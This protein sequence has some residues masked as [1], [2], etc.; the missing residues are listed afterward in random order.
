MKL[1]S[2]LTDWN[3]RGYYLAMVK[4]RLFSLCPDCSVLDIS[5]SIEPF[6]IMQAAF[7]LRETYSSFPEGSV[8]IVGVL[9]EE[10]GQ[11]SH[12]VVRAHNQY[13]IGADTGLFS[14][15]FAED[16]M[17]VFELDIPADS[18]QPTFPTYHRFLQAAVSLA[19]GRAIEDI[20][21][22]T[23]T[24]KKKFW[25]LPVVKEDSI[26][27]HVQYIDNYENLIVNID[28]SLFERVGKGREFMVNLR[29]NKVSR[30]SGQYSAVPVGEI[31]MFFNI[32][33]FLEI[34]INQGNAASLLGFSV[35]DIVRIEFL[36]KPS[37]T[38]PPEKLF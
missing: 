31:A 10:T 5:H 24:W 38:K 14:L 19:E 30:L 6:N 25:L 21:V 3:D 13:F 35:N 27:G 12:I 36:Q 9:A 7:V 11:T 37:G 26:Q 15:V 1:I 34:A 4:A 8:H 28:R 29:G 32:S 20:A 22:K 17:E 16:E 18:F 2:L 23:E 33:G